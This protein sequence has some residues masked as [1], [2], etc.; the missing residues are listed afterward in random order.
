MAAM[1]LAI[2]VLLFAVM[3]VF[4]AEALPKPVALVNHYVP[5]YPKITVPPGMPFQKAIK[6]NITSIVDEPWKIRILQRFPTAIKKDDLLVVDFWVKG[7]SSGSKLYV[8][9][10]ERRSPW[11]PSAKL[12][13]NPA[14]DWEHVVVAG[15]CIGDFP[16]NEQELVISLGYGKQILAISEIQVDNY[17]Q[18]KITPEEITQIIKDAAALKK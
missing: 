5:D 3:P 4:A 18:T 16:A 13:V 15:K 8:Q 9:V 17:G 6:A 12:S 10:Q 7:I 1:R 2:L 14:D 11:R